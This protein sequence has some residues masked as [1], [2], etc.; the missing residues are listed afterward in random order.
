MQAL[1]HSRHYK[2]HLNY[3]Y[4]VT[5]CDIAISYIDYNCTYDITTPC[6]ES[7]DYTPLVNSHRCY[8]RYNIWHPDEPVKNEWHEQYSTCNGDPRIFLP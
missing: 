4:R 3:I 2:R 7:M 8:E 6:Y 1:W 5:V